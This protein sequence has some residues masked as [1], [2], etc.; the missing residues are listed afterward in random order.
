VSPPAGLVA[1]VGAVLDVG[2]HE[3]TLFKALRPSQTAVGKLTTIQAPKAV[4]D[5]QQGHGSRSMR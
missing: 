2:G 5:A 4:V 3:N 1:S